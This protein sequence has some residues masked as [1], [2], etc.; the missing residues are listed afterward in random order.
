MTKRDHKTKP[1]KPETTPIDLPYDDAELIFTVSGGVQLLMTDSDENGEI[2]FNA[3]LAGMLWA[4]LNR[5]PMWAAELVTELEA[6]AVQNG[7]LR[8]TQKAAAT[9]KSRGAVLE[10]VSHALH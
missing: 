10:G 6:W 8:L 2:P 4:R 9:A 3:A 1:R 5:D 7:V